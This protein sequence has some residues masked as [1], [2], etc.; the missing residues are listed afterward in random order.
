MVNA[1]SYES[2]QRHAASVALTF[3]VYW[4]GR[5]RLIQYSPNSTIFG[6]F[7]S[8]GL[9]IACMV[10]ELLNPVR[11]ENMGARS[12]SLYTIA[13]FFVGSALIFPVVS[14]ILRL[15]P[16]SIL[17]IICFNLISAGIHSLMYL[18]SQYTQP[19]TSDN[20]SNAVVE[21]PSCY[22]T[23]YDQTEIQKHSSPIE[24]IVHLFWGSLLLQHVLTDYLVKRSD[25]KIQRAMVKCGV[26][27]N[28]VT[29]R[30][31][32][33]KSQFERCL[34]KTIYIA[35]RACDWVVDYDH[36]W[37]RH[38]YFPLNALQSVAWLLAHIDTSSMSRF[39]FYAAQNGKRTILIEVRC[40]LLARKCF[41]RADRNARRIREKITTH[42]RPISS[43]L[44]A[45]VDRVIL[46][47]LCTKFH[48]M[49]DDLMR[50]E[51]KY[52]DQAVHFIV[53]GTCYLLRLFIPR[54]IISWF[55][56]Q[57]V[58][59]VVAGGIYGTH[60]IFVVLEGVLPLSREFG[61]GLLANASSLPLDD[62]AAMMHALWWGDLAA[63][64]ALGHICLSSIALILILIN[65]AA[66]E[67]LPECEITSQKELL[68]L[69]SNFSPQA[70]KFARLFYILA[71]RSYHYQSPPTTTIWRKVNETVLYYLSA[72][73]ARCAAVGGR[74][75]FLCQLRSISF[76]HRQAPAERHH[77]V[78]IIPLKNLLGFE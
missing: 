69:S 3:V 26:P 41:Y 18:F 73:K 61:C 62:G 38:L 66:K 49:H 9:G 50:R 60:S 2:M 28:W 8:S 13:N 57:T 5:S 64:L 68:L 30:L 55:K 4:A 58:K 43:K 77:Q 6:M 36:R 37:I 25:E 76:I 21:L 24:A 53:D 7:L 16:A 10:C 44:S 59:Y 78:N 74:W 23:S 11:E 19:P 34:S 14:Y 35:W 65:N 70:E 46:R 67:K 42:C 32:V 54:F 20:A 51:E 31:S 63:T 33:L 52:L 12:S 27:S 48:D 75:P 22:N 72:V 17:C 1:V 39:V 29:L 15:N 47:P 40:A 56:C 45:Q 71:P